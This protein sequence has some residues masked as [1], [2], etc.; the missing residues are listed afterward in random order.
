MMKG[1]VSDRKERGLSR[2]CKQAIYSG[3]F[4]PEY[5]SPVSATAAAVMVRRYLRTNGSSLPPPGG[6][7]ILLPQSLLSLFTD[8]L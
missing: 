7:V 6:M 5:T 3:G 1:C 2:Q 4:I 8:R